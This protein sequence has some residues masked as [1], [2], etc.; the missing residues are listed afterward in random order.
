MDS[1]KN[2][3]H[4]IWRVGVVIVVITTMWVNISANSQNI[5]SLKKD[6]QE[7]RSRLREVD[8]NKERYKNIEKQLRI[9]R[10]RIENINDDK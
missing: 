9:I 4:L 10:D 1:I 7:V 6:N 3:I 5:E 2:N 8:R